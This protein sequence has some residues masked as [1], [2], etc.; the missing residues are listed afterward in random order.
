MLLLLKIKQ[1][2]L[3]FVLLLVPITDFMIF[4]DFLILNLFISNWVLKYSRSAFL[5]IEFIVI[6]VVYHFIGL[7]R[8]S[9]TQFI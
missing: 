6:C 7:C 8:V 1:T 3:G 2:F 5:F 9:T 4:Q